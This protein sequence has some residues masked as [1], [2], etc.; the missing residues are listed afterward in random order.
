MARKG[1]LSANLTNRIVEEADIR[2]RRYRIN[3]EQQRGFYLFVYPSGR[4]AFGVRYTT[5]SGKE[6][7]RV[8][9]DY[10]GLLPSQ[11]RALAAKL[12]ADVVT[13]QADPAAERS[14]A[15]RQGQERRD[16]TIATLAKTYLEHQLKRGEKAASTLAKE[17]Q[18]IKNHIIPRLGSVSAA[19]LTRLDVEEALFA[20]RDDA[21]SK[22]GKSGA[23][24]ANDCRKY[25]RQICEFGV[26][27]EWLPTNP[28]DLI[29]AFAEE[30]RERVA[31]D[32]ELTRL[33]QRWEARKT[34]PENSD[35]LPRGWA[36]AAAMQFAALTLQRGE[37]VV[38]AEWS[39]I[40]WDGL[41]W[42]IPRNRR[43]DRRALAVPLSEASLAILRDAWDHS[44]TAPDGPWPGPFIGRRDAAIKRMSLTQAFRRDCAA[45]GIADLTPH[46]LRRTG[47]TAITNPEKL[48]FPPH[49]GEAV[50]GHV[51]GSRLQRTYDLNDYL[52]EKRRALEGWGQWLLGITAGE[53]A[54][55][56]SNIVPLRAGG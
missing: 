47:R 1:A 14:A 37:E 54:A 52:S 20:I 45:L 56:T 36:G 4:K 8:I 2:E 30:P 10:P 49:I 48:G 42:L 41:L 31:T 21:A 40:D 19:D 13:A 23:S 53:R 15:R 38:S 35:G 17:T 9:G 28:V 11:A 44:E 43:K 50:I 46:D 29:P 7:D 39:E 51:I 24:A 18:H 55:E 5:S 34:P 12:R 22:S 16:R 32:D 27:R 6:S 3:D 25:L 26:V 33:W